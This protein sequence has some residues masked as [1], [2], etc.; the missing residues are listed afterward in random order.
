MTFCAKT[1]NLFKNNAKTASIYLFIKVTC[2]LH[3]LLCAGSFECLE[4]IAD[5]ENTLN[6]LFEYAMFCMNTMQLKQANLISDTKVSINNFAT[7]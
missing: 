1:M 4:N 5:I 6:L 3:L 7:I 2:L